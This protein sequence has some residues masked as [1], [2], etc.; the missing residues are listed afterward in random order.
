M[1]MAIENPPFIDDFSSYKHPLIRD[2][3]LFSTGEYENWRQ[4]S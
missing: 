3:P 1:N 2:S 4:M